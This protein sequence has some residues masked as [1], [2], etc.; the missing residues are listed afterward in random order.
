MMLRWGKKGCDF[1]WSWSASLSKQSEFDLIWFDCFDTIR[2]NALWPCK[3]IKLQ[4]QNQ[5]PHHIRMYINY[6]PQIICLLIT[7][8]ML[9]LNSRKLKL[10]TFSIWMHN[11]LLEKRVRVRTKCFSFFISFCASITSS[12][13]CFLVFVLFLHLLWIIKT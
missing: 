2:L 5:Q 12:F 6:L 7:M 8:S 10:N 4:M 9:S 3:T 11:F 13:L 1:T